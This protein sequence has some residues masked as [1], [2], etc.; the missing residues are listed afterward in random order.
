MSRSA[1]DLTRFTATVPHAYSKISTLRSAFSPAAASV[2]K[3]SS[4]TRKLPSPPSHSLPSHFIPTPNA[5][6]S[7]PPRPPPP[8]PSETPAEKVARLRSARFE[9]RKAQFSLWDRMVVGGRIWADRLHRITVYFLLLVSGMFLLNG[10]HLD[11][12]TPKTPCPL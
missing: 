7:S 3:N 4:S 2:A 6:P 1:I 5:S 10:S 8:R 11:H 9:A 12:S